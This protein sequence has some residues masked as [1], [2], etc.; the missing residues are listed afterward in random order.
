ME[1]IRSYNGDPQL[2][3]NVI[4]SIAYINNGWGLFPFLSSKMTYD[5]FKVKWHSQVTLLL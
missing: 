1:A 3:G 4:I 2:L 5:I